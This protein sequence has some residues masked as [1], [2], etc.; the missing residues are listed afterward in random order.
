MPHTTIVGKLTEAFNQPRCPR[1]SPKHL[2]AI[3]SAIAIC[4]S[5]S[6]IPRAPRRAHNRSCA[7]RHDAGSIRS[8]RRTTAIYSR[9]PTLRS[10][11][12]CAQRL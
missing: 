3:E 11:S 12:S 7:R 1:R 6:N 9:K 2:L 5:P 8:K 10:S 4:G